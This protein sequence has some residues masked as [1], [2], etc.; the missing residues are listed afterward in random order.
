MVQKL[1]FAVQQ[2]EQTKLK[3]LKYHRILQLNSELLA[4]KTVQYEEKRKYVRKILP[5]NLVPRRDAEEQLREMNTGL[6]N[7]RTQLLIVKLL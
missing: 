3:V 4:S 6:Q 1:N 5:D 7:V 2:L